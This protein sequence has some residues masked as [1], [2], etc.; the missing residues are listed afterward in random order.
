MASATGGEVASV[1]AVAASAEEVA[2]TAWGADVTLATPSPAASAAPA[3]RVKNGPSLDMTAPGVR[4]VSARAS[5]LS[6]RLS[7]N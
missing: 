7:V 5:A 4:M 2:V 3:A 6:G 1:D